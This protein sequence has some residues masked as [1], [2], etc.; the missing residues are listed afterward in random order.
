MVVPI[1]RFTSLMS[2]RPL[3]GA[4]IFPSNLYYTSR[5]F[6]S[7]AMILD[8][9][10]NPF[11]FERWERKPDKDFEYIDAE[12]VGE[13]KDEKS[14]TTLSKLLKPIETIRRKISSAFTS[15]AESVGIIE[16]KEKSAKERQLAEF[17]KLMDE[18]PLTRSGGL[19]GG[20]FGQMVKFVGRSIFQSLGKRCLFVKLINS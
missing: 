18:F 9:N 13:N 12:V 15:A 11:K 4:L 16:R 17:D 1:I 14:K 10:R 3:I 8:R 2:S 20:I 5:P 6:F 7:S 19:V